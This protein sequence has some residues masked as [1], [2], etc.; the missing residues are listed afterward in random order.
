MGR[1][2]GSNPRPSPSFPTR[3]IDPATNA[4][5]SASQRRGTARNSA[6]TPAATAG[7]ITAGRSIEA[8]VSPCASTSAR[9]SL[10]SAAVSARAAAHSAHAA[11]D[12]AGNSGEGEGE[13]AE[14]RGGGQG[15]GAGVPPA[16]PGPSH[17][18]SDPRISATTRTSSSSSRLS[19]VRN[20]PSS[21]SGTWSGA[22]IR[23]R[24]PSSGEQ[25][26]SPFSETSARS[27]DHASAGT[28]TAFASGRRRPCAHA[29]PR[30]GPIP[31]AL[32]IG[33][34]FH[35]RH[36]R[37]HAA[38]TRNAD[39]GVASSS[40]VVSRTAARSAARALSA[41]SVAASA[42]AFT[43]RHC[44]HTAP[45]PRS[46]GEPSAIPEASTRMRYAAAE[47]RLIADARDGSANPC[48]HRMDA[49]SNGPGAATSSQNERIHSAGIQW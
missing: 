4:R 20:P 40:S 19:P 33:P 12:H 23:G 39:P 38:E 34:V 11:E 10:F 24:T 25:T 5:Q 31:T 13:G 14:S 1:H 37:N 8:H 22:A 44:R 42:R 7:S 49:T 18:R 45:G 27:R 48:G 9:R 47:T 26:S 35:A 28:A 2:A 36:A 6:T 15:G 29:S 41:V 3:V 16:R 43:R 30:V 46:V 32:G 17:P 21:S